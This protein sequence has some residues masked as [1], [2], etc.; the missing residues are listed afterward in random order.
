MS[1]YS[2]ISDNNNNNNG[3]AWDRYAFDNFNRIDGFLPPTNMFNN[4]KGAVESNNFD[5]SGPLTT[6]PRSWNMSK[7]TV[8]RKYS[9]TKDIATKGNKYYTNTGYNNDSIKLGDNSKVQV[10]SP[11]NLDI[12]TKS[13]TKA[14]KNRLQFYTNPKDNLIHVYDTNSGEDALYFFEEDGKKQYLTFDNSS[15]TTA[16][17]GDNIF[18][19]NPAQQSRASDLDSNNIPPLGKVTLESPSATNSGNS[20][21]STHS[22]EYKIGSSREKVYNPDK[23]SSWLASEYNSK[24]IPGIDVK[25]QIDDTSMKSI[26]D[27]HLDDNQDFIARNFAKENKD[28]SYAFD[29][30]SYETFSKTMK[31]INTTLNETFGENFIGS[32]DSNTQNGFYQA[33]N[34]SLVDGKFDKNTF[35]KNL[36]DKYQIVDTGF[37]E[38]NMELLG[39]RM[40]SGM[41]SEQVHDFYDDYLSVYTTNSVN[42]NSPGAHKSGQLD[43]SNAGTQF[44]YEMTNNN[45]DREQAHTIGSM[46]ASHNNSEIEE[47][48]ASSNYDYN[49][50]NKYQQDEYNRLVQENKDIK[51]ATATQDDSIDWEKWSSVGSNVMSMIQAGYQI[52]VAYEQLEDADNA[53]EQAEEHH[54]E[55]IDMQK[56]ELAQKQAQRNSSVN[57]LHNVRI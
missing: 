39:L 34:D 46:I 56:N 8:N 35:Y 43:W 55:L 23:K 52:Y 38:A 18:V 15:K 11:K 30:E 22:F 3:Y 20:N 48:M 36:T 47:L 19:N 54:N 7:G 45:L 5:W 2:T 41:T 50:L 10:M 37:N 17:S 9:S 14:T 29:K 53:Y 13:A 12:W 51:T 49:Q 24:K 16:S 4:L 40:S 57:A 26:Q 44:L 27:L 32:L 25:M 6:P 31:G 33:M 42:P 28:G 21:S 1:G